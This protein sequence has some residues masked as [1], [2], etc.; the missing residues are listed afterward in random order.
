M[1]RNESLNKH[2]S[3]HLR[4]HD[5]ILRFFG[6]LGRVGLIL[7]SVAGVL[8]WS[9]LTLYFLNF[10][11][12]RGGL[13]EYLLLGSFWLYLAISLY[14]A[15]KLRRTRTLVILAIVLNTALVIEEI[16]AAAKDTTTI[17]FGWQLALVF[18]V[19]WAFLCIGGLRANPDGNEN[20]Q[21]AS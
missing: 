18:A 19:L 2:S 21:S 3:R 4:D 16:W 1:E 9:Y 14:T 13:T 5:R 10:V 6:L 12:R 15:I 8:L 7:A 11:G 17:R 20:S